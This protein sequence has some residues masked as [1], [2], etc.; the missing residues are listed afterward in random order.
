MFVQESH[1]DSKITQEKVRTGRS[2]LLRPWITGAPALVGA[3]GSQGKYS[4]GS[5]IQT[6]T[7]LENMDSPAVG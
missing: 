3:G 6:E 4:P 1:V 5:D 7:W 2:L